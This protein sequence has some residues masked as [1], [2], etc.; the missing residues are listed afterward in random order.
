M[1]PRREDI[2]DALI[3]ATAKRYEANVWTF[4]RDF[5]RLLPKAQVRLLRRSQDGER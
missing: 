5:L 3:A 4:D 2:P 1:K